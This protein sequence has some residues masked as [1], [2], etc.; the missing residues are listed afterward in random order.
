MLALR[1]EI[2]SEKHL[3]TIL[4]IENLILTWRQQGQL[5]EAER[6]KVEVLILRKEILSK[7]YLDTIR[8]MAH[9]VATL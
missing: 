8:A 6:L 9:L 1:K 5:D 2:L 7:K 3:D 4:A